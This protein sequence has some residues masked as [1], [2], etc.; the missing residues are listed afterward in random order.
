MVAHR[1]TLQLVVIL[2]VYFRMSGQ[3]AVPPLRG[4]SSTLRVSQRA[5]GQHVGPNI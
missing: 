4:A 3:S 2:H 1:V 5:S